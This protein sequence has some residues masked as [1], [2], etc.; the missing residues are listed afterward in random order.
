MATEKAWPEASG[1][2]VKQSQDCLALAI[3]ESTA[4]SVRN[5]KAFSIIADKAAKSIGV[6][7]KCDQ[8][9]TK[10]QLQK[11]LSRVEGT[12]KDTPALGYG[13]VV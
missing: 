2:S 9:G 4:A 1:A 10:V 11:L 5:S 8:C 6:L 3:V 7:T 12:A 13:Y